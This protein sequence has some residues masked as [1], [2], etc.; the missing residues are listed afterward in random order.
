MNIF[1][2]FSHFTI[3]VQLGTVSNFYHMLIIMLGNMLVN[4][5]MKIFFII[6]HVFFIF[7]HEISR[8]IVFKI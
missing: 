3:F 8:F 7:N 5:D 1:L 2:Y 6:S 4:I